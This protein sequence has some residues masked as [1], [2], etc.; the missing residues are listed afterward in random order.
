MARTAFYSGSF[1]PLTNGHLDVIERAAAL[2]DRLVVG[3]GANASKS[4]LF[5]TDERIAMIHA[6][7]AAL[8]GLAL[9][10]I[11]FTGLAVEAARAAGA[12]I[13]LRG[14]RDDTDFNYEMQMAGM[15]GAMAPL[16]RTVFVPASPQVRHV[17]STLVRQIASLGGDV[18]AF[19]PP[20]VAAALAARFS[21][22]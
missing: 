11:T 2:C 17:S 12:S 14:L 5:S 6:A 1:D 18:S 20:N 19:V 4:A 21:K 9:E 3:V 22:G 16:L 15:N 7:G 8:G 10:A 13:I